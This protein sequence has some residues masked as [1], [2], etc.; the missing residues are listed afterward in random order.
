MCEK[1][2]CSE[3]PD[4]HQTRMCF[5]SNENEQSAN[6]WEDDDET[7]MISRDPYAQTPNQNRPQLRSGNNPQNTSEGT[8]RRPRPRGVPGSA[9]FYE[10]I[11]GEERPARSRPTRQS[12]AEVEARL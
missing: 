6:A 10:E 1:Q 5:M 9:H 7:G 8:G 4:R 11:E 12:R 3:K 2:R